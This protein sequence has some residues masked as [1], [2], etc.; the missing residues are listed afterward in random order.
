VNRRK[1]DQ[2]KRQTNTE[3]EHHSISLKSNGRTE[4]AVAAAVDH[5]REVF[6]CRFVESADMCPS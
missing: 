3:I 5:L 1:A 6:P 2:D 4:R